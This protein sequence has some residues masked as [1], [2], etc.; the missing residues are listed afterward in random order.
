VITHR[1]ASELIAA[2]EDPGSPVGYPGALLRPARAEVE[3][4]GGVRAPEPSYPRPARTRDRG[5]P[6]R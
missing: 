1:H 5:L 4:R 2:P 3:R 6:R